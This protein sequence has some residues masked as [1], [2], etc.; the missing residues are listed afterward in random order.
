MGF[1]RRFKGRQVAVG[2]VVLG[3]AITIA[4]TRVG[5]LKGT[6]PTSSARREPAPAF[7][8]I[9][10][11]LNSP[12]LTVRGLHGRVVLIDFWAYS[13]V[14]CIRTVPAL[15]ELYARYHPFGLEIV[16]VHA[17]EFNFEKRPSNVQEAIRRN[18]IL[19]PVALDNDMD[20]W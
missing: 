1:V 8:G 10:G 18:K 9:A 5:F 3:I 6:P 14:N 17:P 12:P 11:W 16:G 7:T 15:R 4:A 13:C 20:T 19:W 2:F